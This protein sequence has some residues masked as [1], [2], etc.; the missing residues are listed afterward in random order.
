MSMATVS[1]R[2]TDSD[3]V[4]RRIVVFIN[5][6]VAVGVVVVALSSFGADEPFEEAVLGIT[7]EAPSLPV[8]TADTDPDGFT[9]AVAASLCN[10]VDGPSCAF[11]H[12]NFGDPTMIDNP[13]LPMRPGTRLVYEGTTNEDNVMLGHRVVITVTDLT[14]IIDGIESVVSWDLDFSNG[15]LVEAEL[16]F[17][18]QDDDGNVW[19]M[20][21]HPEE[22]EGG[23]L[24][25]APTW[26]AGIAGAKAGIS[27]LGKPV[28]G[29]LSYSQGW[30]PAVEFID[31]AQVAE[32]GVE[33]CVP[34]GCFTDVL[35]IDEFNTE[36]ANARQLKFF[37]PGVGNIRVDWT[38]E[39]E[40]QEELELVSVTLLDGNELVEVRAAA[41]ELESH[42][43]EISPTVY[44]R[45]Q[46]MEF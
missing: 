37:A 24:V 16:A 28:V 5:W 21:E 10:R 32:S 39:D 43:Y 8:A 23:V 36:E 41:L 45:T 40:T 33:T 38:G 6:V 20:G 19:R 30:G 46:P 11:D 31:R 17:F 44:G 34:A 9:S 13:W 2:R 42:A 22:Y 15:E 26:L 25:D 7:L 29:T 4:R 14:K 35:I 12:D 3:E 27:I 18:A 1:R